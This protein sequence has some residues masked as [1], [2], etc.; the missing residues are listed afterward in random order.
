[1]SNIKYYIVKREY[2]EGTFFHDLTEC[3][4]FYD[5]VKKKIRKKRNRSH[6]TYR[7]E[8]IVTKLLFLKG[9][10][11]EEDDIKEIDKDIYNFLFKLRI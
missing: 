1:M 3:I 11:L 2:I 8:K 4:S 10:K 9:I 6:I 5:D 7:Y